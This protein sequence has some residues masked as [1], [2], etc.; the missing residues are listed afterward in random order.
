LSPPGDLIARGVDPASLVV[1]HSGGSTGTPVCIRRTR[2]EDRL[3]QAYRLA[4]L[5]RLGMKVTDRR[6]AIVMGSRQAPTLLSRLGLLRHEELDCTLPAEALLGQLRAAAP[7][8]LRGYPGTLSW[9]AGQLT[10]QD[11][12]S[13]RPRFITTDSEMMTADMRARI[14]EGFGVGVIDFY[15]SHEFN[16]IA[17]ECRHGGT[18][19]VSDCSMIAEIVK[20]GRPAAPGEAGELVGTALHSWAVPY[21][22]Y[23][24]D[25]V[26]TRGPLHCSCGAPN[27]TIAHIQGRM[28]DRFPLPGGRTIHPYTL[29]RPLLNS[30]PWIRRFQI[31]QE[32]LGRIRVR[33][34]PMPGEAPGPEALAKLEHALAASLEEPMTFAIDLTDSIPSAANGKFRPYY[35]MV[36]R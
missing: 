36:P 34:V 5:F 15:D 28:L 4:V 20:D 6:A 11:R 14:R 35:S 13:I 8:V 10:A 7:D 25:D 12:A 17:W 19:H 22:R 9:V 24:L 30:S 23:C 27:A 29:V 32:Q 1:H 16:M 3:L 33:V 31:V 26:V 2:F 18:Y 21:I